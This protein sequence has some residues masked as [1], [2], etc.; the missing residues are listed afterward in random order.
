MSYREPAQAVL[1]RTLVLERPATAPAEVPIQTPARTSPPCRPDVRSR[2][3]RLAGT[4]HSRHAI[5]CPR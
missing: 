1:R 5:R 2:R 3:R 4:R